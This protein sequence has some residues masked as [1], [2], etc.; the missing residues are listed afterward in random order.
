MLP[1]NGHHDDDSPRPLDLDQTIRTVIC[2]SY[3]PRAPR[4]AVQAAIGEHASASDELH[5]SHPTAPAS[6]TGVLLYS[7]LI[8]LRPGRTEN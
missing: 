5:G 2:T 6:H 4:S 7:A 3:T 1:E 8:V